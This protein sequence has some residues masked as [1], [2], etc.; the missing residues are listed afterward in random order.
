MQPFVSSTDGRASLWLDWDRIEK[1]TEEKEK[2]LIEAESCIGVVLPNWYAEH[3]IPIS[4]LEYTGEY[5]D[6]HD[7][8]RASVS[9]AWNELSARMRQREYPW[10]RRREINGRAMVTVGVTGL[11]LKNAIDNLVAAIRDTRAVMQI[12]FYDQKNPRHV[13]RARVSM[14]RRDRAEESFVIFNRDEPGDI[15]R[16]E[17]YMPHDHKNLDVIIDKLRVAS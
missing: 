1:R 2:Q 7:D 3:T 14:E 15:Y 9:V 16:H 11:S 6:E 12:Q 17:W 13:E 8:C 10:L 5:E 4:T